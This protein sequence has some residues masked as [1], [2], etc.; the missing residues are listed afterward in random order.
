MHGDKRNISKDNFQNLKKKVRYRFFLNSYLDHAFTRCPKCRMTTR[1]RKFCLITHIEPRY[2]ISLNKTCRYCPNCDL[3]ILNQ[4]EL[5]NY[6]YAICERNFPDVIGK[7][8]FLLGT[9]DRKDWKEGKL[10]AFNSRQTI[11]ELTHPFKEV[12]NF[13]VILGGWKRN[14]F[15]R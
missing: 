9:M 14:S 8:Y 11:E 10:N 2:L 15:E 1:V 3:V 4:Q 12:W 7:D 5:E 6:L 13:D